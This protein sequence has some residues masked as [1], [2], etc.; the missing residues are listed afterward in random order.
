MSDANGNFAGALYGKAEARSQL[1]SSEGSRVEQRNDLDDVVH[2]LPLASAFRPGL[3]D[4]FL[5]SNA[6]L[7]LLA[8]LREICGER[9]AL[10]ERSVPCHDPL[11]EPR[12]L[13]TVIL[14]LRFERADARFP[15]AKRCAITLE[16]PQRCEQVVPRV[17]ERPLA[18]PRRGLKRLLPQLERLRPNL[19]FNADLLEALARG[20]VIVLRGLRRQRPGP[21]L[22]DPART[23]EAR[24]N[25][26]GRA[27]PAVFAVRL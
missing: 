21:V 26:R 24:G 3:A 16:H 7:R 12:E 23:F 14:D 11:N 8:S 1:R 13:P 19:T 9:F 4:R 22:P 17:G 10:G 2:G 25:G 20:V 6:P 18:F 27:A 15:S 5:R